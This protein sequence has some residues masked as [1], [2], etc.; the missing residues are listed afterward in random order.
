ME[1]PGRL[2][3]LPKAVCVVSLPMR[4][5]NKSGNGNRVKAARVVSLPMRDGNLASVKD[6]RRDIEVVSLPMRDGNF[7]AS[8]TSL[9][10]SFGVVSLPMR[11]GNSECR[12]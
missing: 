7:F 10:L 11:D 3:A 5:G 2:P 9:Y 6:P 8:A 4:D 12:C 1:T